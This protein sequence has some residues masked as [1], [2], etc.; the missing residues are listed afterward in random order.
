MASGR[1]PLRAPLGGSA[2]LASDFRTADVSAARQ[3]RWIGND[4]FP[5]NRSLAPIAGAPPCKASAPPPP[6]RIIPSDANQRRAV[7]RTLTN[8]SRE[9]GISYRA[10][11][12]TGRGYL[13]S[14]IRLAP[15]SKKRIT[16]A[17]V[18]P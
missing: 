7:R 6:R 16:A 12:F 14:S 13:L 17:R 5:P 3:N 10:P 15:K 18:W 2:D 4:P 11:I 9:T 8:A 1:N